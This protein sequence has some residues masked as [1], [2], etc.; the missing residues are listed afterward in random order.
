MAAEII[1]PAILRPMTSGADTVQ[2][3]GSTIIAIIND[4]EARFPG[5]KN[6]LCDDS[7]NTHRF[8]NI[9]LNGEDI[10][11]LNQLDT[12]VHDSDEITIVPAIAGG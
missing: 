2:S 10:R 3:H 7:G 9:Y 1:I 12:P 4:L 6:R 8:V 5:I 11:S